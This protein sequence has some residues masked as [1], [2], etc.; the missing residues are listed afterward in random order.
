[1]G[2]EPLVKSGRLVQ[3]P[4]NTWDFGRSPTACLPISQHPASDGGWRLL[5][6]SGENIPEDSGP[7][8]RL[9]LYLGHPLPLPPLPA[10]AAAP[11]TSRIED[12]TIPENRVQLP[13]RAGPEPFITTAQLAACLGCSARWVE[14]RAHDGMP[15]YRWGGMT[16]YRLSEVLDWLRENR[17]A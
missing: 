15:A 12:R 6:A 4:V 2:A 13:G 3:L 10:G 14:A 16:R 11:S 8:G 9:R 5:R 17:A 1:M 7:N